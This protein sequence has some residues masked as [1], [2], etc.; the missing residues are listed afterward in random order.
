MFIHAMQI[1]KGQNLTLSM[2]KFS[3]KSLLYFHHNISSLNVANGY[4]RC[5]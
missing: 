2:L 5:Q 4:F 3:V 1:K